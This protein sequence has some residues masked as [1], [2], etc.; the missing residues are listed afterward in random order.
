MGHPMRMDGGCLART[1]F[2]TFTSIHADSEPMDRGLVVKNDRICGDFLIGSA[3]GFTSLCSST[4]FL[5]L[6]AISS[7]AASLAI[8]L[9]GSYL[10]ML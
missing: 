1:F 3:H 7:G 8:R 9:T 4:P 10:A 2:S 6:P 5:L